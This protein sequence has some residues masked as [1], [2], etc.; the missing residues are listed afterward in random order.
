MP[1]RSRRLAPMAMVDLPQPVNPHVFIRGNPGRP[2]D[3]VPRR[4]LEVC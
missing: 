4:F 3:A 2:G 1:A